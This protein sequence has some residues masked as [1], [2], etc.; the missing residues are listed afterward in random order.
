MRKTEPLEYLIEFVKVLA[1]VVI[2]YIVIKALLTV[3]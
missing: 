2:G 1:I 3:V